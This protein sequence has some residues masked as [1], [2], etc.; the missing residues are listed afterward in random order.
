MLERVISGGQT[1]VDQAALRAAQAC[2]LETGG[3]A[4]LG[5][6]TEE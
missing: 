3:Y 5:W 2:G 6:E 4:P 1:G